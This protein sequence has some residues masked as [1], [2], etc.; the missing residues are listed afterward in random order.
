MEKSGTSEGDMESSDSED[1]LM[2]G[3]KKRLSAESELS[4][5][6]YRLNEM[7]PP[8]IMG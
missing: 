3:K 1:E 2:M 4:M 5:Y 7:T 8:L 6:V